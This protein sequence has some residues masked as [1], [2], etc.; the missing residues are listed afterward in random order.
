MK[1]CNFHP[2]GFGSTIIKRACR[3]TLQAEAYA[4]QAGVE[5]G[6]RIRAAIADCKGVL[7]MKRWEAT[8]AASMPQIWITD[9]A[10]VET[11]LN[12]LTNSQL[13][14]KRLGIE[15]AALRQSL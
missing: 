9:C 1:K 6:D 8:S 7:D 3:S 14:D 5:E 4:L 10:S 15:M 12:N 13:S 2:I 11:H